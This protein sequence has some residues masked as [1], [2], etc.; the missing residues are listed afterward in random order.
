M[1]QE[2][3]TEMENRI[4]DAATRA[5]VRKG[6]AG[7]SMQDIAEEAGINRTLLN[8]YFRSKDKLFDLIFQRV[9]V[10]FLPDLAAEINAEISLEEKIVRVVD[11]YYSIL[12]E[13]PYASVFI[14]HELSADPSRL[15]Q[16]MRKQ[17][18]RPDKLMGEFK[19]EMD[20]GRLKTAD[21]RQLLVNLLGL[22]IFPFAARTVIEGILFS[23]DSKAFD[24]F[25]DERREYI[26]TYFIE[27]IKV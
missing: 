2:L 5:F 18:I 27:S 10:S 13:S 24:R 20:A 16:S 3:N 21:P 12:K 14:I 17:G 26:K 8:Y 7:T 6:K 22:I 23:N 1:T 4:V 11:R 19:T 9:F 25:L 15:V